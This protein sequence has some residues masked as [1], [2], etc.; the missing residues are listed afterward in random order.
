MTEE[1]IRVAFVEEL[2]RIAPDIAPDDI[3]DNDHLQDDLGL[4]SMDV[5]NL[6]TAL[7]SRVGVDIPEVDYP[8]LS[9]L[10]SAAAYIFSKLT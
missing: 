3:D 1:E 4:D 9:T 10:P 6:V 7:H 2:V 8:K 5:L